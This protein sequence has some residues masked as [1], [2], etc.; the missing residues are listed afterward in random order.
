M[1]VKRN[2]QWQH[3]AHDEGAQGVVAENSLSNCRR[4][5][6]VVQ[7]GTGINESAILTI[8]LLKLSEPGLFFR[9]R[10]NAACP[11]VLIKFL[12]GSNLGTFLIRL[13]HSSDRSIV[14]EAFSEIIFNVITAR[15]RLEYFSFIIGYLSQLL[16]FS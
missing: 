5:P 11:R 9:Y 14:S 6:Q 8:V 13:F 1:H 10:G 16:C 3:L 15:R 2:H 7:T 12:L 4:A